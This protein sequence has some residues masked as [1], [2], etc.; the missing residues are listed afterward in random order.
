M[1]STGNVS[2]MDCKTDFHA[3]AEYLQHRKERV[4]VNPEHLDSQSESF[5]KDQKGQKTNF[6]YVQP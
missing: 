3:Q 1:K 2:D 6:I 4:G 5:K